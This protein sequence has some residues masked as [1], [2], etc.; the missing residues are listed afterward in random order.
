MSYCGMQD[1]AT[2]TSRPKATLSTAGCSSDIACRP[3]P[4]PLQAM[5][6]GHLGLGRGGGGASA[7]V[8]PALTKEG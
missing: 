4:L 8:T 2:S 6:L 3:E 5:H 7:E 1:H